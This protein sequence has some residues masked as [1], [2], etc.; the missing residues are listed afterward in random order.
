MGRQPV[1]VTS[2]LGI[3]AL[4]LGGCATIDESVGAAGPG[5]PRIM[6]LRFDPDMVRSGES[7]QMSFYFEVGSADVDECVVVERGLSQFQF[8]TALQP[9][10]IPLRQYVGLAA[11]TVEIPLRWTDTGIRS[12]EVYVVTTQG[13]QSN[14]LRATLTVR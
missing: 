8:Y 6:N 13:K 4:I 12:I 7:A 2:L 10:T 11:G 1:V 5:V 9:M 14:R 3:V